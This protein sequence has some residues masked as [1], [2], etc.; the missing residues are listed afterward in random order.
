MS[1]TFPFIVFTAVSSTFF[2]ACG[3][4]SKNSGD[5]D[6]SAEQPA[7]QGRF[8]LE[9]NCEQ[10]KENSETEY[11][12]A[13]RLGFLVEDEI[14]SRIGIHYSSPDCRADTLQGWSR[15]WVYKQG[16]FNQQEFA[17]TTLDWKEEDARLV[18]GQ[19]AAEAESFLDASREITLK[20]LDFTES[21]DQNY[22]V[23]A[24]VGNLG[25]GAMPSISCFGTPLKLE[26]PSSGG[27]I[28]TFRASP[29]LHD[30]SPR[31]RDHCSILVGFPQGPNLLTHIIGVSEEFMLDFRAKS[32][33]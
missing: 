31:I 23:R 3:Q 30:D 10:I 27:N 12:A 13:T 6:T 11:D 8:Y 26:N 5:P 9:E 22:I 25:E 16:T 29:N 19:S 17:G 15:H 21:S 24:E 28:F 32:D 2:G 1:K 4:S 14:I 33:R 20:I 18:I 7:H